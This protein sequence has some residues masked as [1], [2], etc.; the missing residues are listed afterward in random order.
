MANYLIIGFIAIL[1]IA[2]FSLVIFVL[3][4]SLKKI[5]EKPGDQQSFLMI[6]NQINEITKTLDSRLG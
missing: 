3:K 4:Q 6:Q 2:G 1:I 5:G